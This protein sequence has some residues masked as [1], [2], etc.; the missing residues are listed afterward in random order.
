[1][2]YD[3]DPSELAPESTNP[4]REDPI[5]LILRGVNAAN[6]TLSHVATEVLELKSRVER[7]EKVD[8]RPRQV[9]YFAL[10]VSLMTLGALL[11]LIVMGVV[12]PAHAFA[13]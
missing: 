7:L 12:Q 6:L 13:R 10:A 11:L 5:E 8:A 3:T 2:S 1:M 9:A 4:G